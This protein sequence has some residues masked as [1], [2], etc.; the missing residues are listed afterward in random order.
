[1][2]SREGTVT[3]GEGIELGLSTFA[4]EEDAA[5]VVRALVEEGLAACGTILPGARSVYQWKGGIE[6]SPE[7]VVLFKLAAANREA[8]ALRLA[9]LHPYQVPEIVFLGP[10]GV[11]GPYRA[12]VLGGAED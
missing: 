7:V 2:E 1:M 3:P 12:W 5:R 10:S 6:E 11:S 9:E 4:S 8:F